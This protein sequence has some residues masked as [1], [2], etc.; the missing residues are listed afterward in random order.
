MKRIVA[1]DIVRRNISKTS[2]EIDDE[3]HDQFHQTINEMISD[4]WQ[5][6]GKPIVKDGVY[7][8]AVV[9]IQRTLKHKVRFLSDEDIDKIMI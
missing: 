4:G 8:Q 5:P 1:Y 6:Y 3:L 7:Y 2:M 9:K